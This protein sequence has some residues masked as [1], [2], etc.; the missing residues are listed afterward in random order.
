MCHSY[1]DAKASSDTLAPLAACRSL[2]FGSAHSYI[3]PPP[4]GWGA[5]GGCGGKEAKPPA[6]PAGTQRKLHFRQRRP[7]RAP[8]P[9]E[10]WGSVRSLRVNDGTAYRIQG[11]RTLSEKGSYIM[12]A[13]R[14]AKCYS[15]L[16]TAVTHE[17]TCHVPDIW[18]GTTT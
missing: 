15:R 13:L 9:H 14:P 1:S 6:P 5:N 2:A 7:W 11:I 3:Y 17:G 16:Q 8:V 12:L 10:G 4:K 18:G